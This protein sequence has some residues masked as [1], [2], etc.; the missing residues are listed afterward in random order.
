MIVKNYYLLGKTLFI[1]DYVFIDLWKRDDGSQ[2]TVAN[3]YR[4]EMTL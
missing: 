2:T 4:C 1:L 3:L